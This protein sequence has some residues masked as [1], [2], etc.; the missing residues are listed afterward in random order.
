MVEDN[1]YM[2]KKSGIATDSEDETD[3]EIEEVPPGVGWIYVGSHN[4]TPSAWGNMSGT[5]FTPILNV[6]NSFTCPLMGLTMAQISNY[7]VGIV[8][9]VK[10]EAEAQ[11]IACFQRRPRRYAAGKDEPWV[12]GA[13]HRMTFFHSFAEL[14]RLYCRYKRNPYT[15]KPSSARHHQTRF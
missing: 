13:S 7:E 9:P 5:G 8:F 11:K 3:D 14:P 6:S 1:A 12:S 10:D 2:S 15:T 4:F